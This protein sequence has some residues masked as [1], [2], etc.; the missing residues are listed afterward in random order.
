MNKDGFYALR[1]HPVVFMALVTIV[2][3]LITSALFL[4]TSE[5]VESNEL[6]FLRRSVLDAASIEHDGTVGG[7]EQAYMKYVKEEGEKYIITYTDGTN[8]TVVERTGAGLWGPITIVV[9]FVDESTLSGVS[10]L[11]Q[12]ETPGL[13]ARIEEPWFTAQ[14]SGKSGPFTFVEEGTASADD[15]ID[16]ITGATRTSQAFRTIINSVIDDGP[17]IYE[18]R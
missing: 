18:E 6:F 17:T 10:I 7:V 4:S 12:N 15:E 8:A 5:R 11:S 13:G 3:I 14:F 9:G 2:C 16:S 1:V